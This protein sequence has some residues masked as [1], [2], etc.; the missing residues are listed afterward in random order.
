MSARQPPEGEGQEEGH[1]MVL[2]IGFVL[3]ALLLTT[4][5]A[6]A[7]SLYLGHKKLLSMADGAALAAAD[8]FVLN[9]G[10][11]SSVPAPCSPT[12]ASPPRLPPTLQAMKPRRRLTACRSQP[13]RAPPT[14]APHR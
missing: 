2:L 4:V 12:T 3:L 9:G 11:A 5:V 10:T 6:G 1:I 8:T 7:S 13:G 14:G